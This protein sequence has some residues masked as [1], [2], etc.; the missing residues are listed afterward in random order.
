MDFISTT[1]TVHLHS[2]ISKTAA[3]YGWPEIG[4]A[5]GTGIVAMALLQLTKDMAPLRRGSQRRWMQN[6]IADS[7]GPRGERGFFERLRHG[8]PVSV[9]KAEDRLIEL[10]TGGNEDAFYELPIEQMVAQMNAAAQVALDNPKYYFD[11]LA[12]LANGAKPDDLSMLRRGT[13]K[14][15]RR[16]NDA[17]SNYLEA[18]S[19]IGHWVQRNLDA[20]QIDFGNRWKFLMQVAAIAISIFLV[21]LSVAL[22]DPQSTVG[23]YLL[24]A[25]IG[26]VAGYLAP[27]FRDIIAALQTWRK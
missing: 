11:L 3:L 24:A 22:A 14:T 16:S 10:A 27:V 23:T 8:A 21:E 9:T 2:A 5:A 12:V 15:S 19:R 26:L 13:S 18:R 7:V 20:I 6:W 17:T 4:L 1:D 25:P